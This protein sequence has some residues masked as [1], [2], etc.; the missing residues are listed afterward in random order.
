M[1]G[2]LVGRKSAVRGRFMLWCT[3]VLV[4]FFAYI[5]TRRVKDVSD[6]VQ[7]VFMAA[8]MSLL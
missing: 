3:D 8:V 1:F 2:G 5:L 6:A 7:P 4:I